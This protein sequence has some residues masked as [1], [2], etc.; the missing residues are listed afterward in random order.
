MERLLTWAR[1]ERDPEVGAAMVWGLRNRDAIQEFLLHPIAPMAREAALGLPVNDNTVYFLVQALLVGR[2]P[3][4]D[5]ILLEKLRGARSGLVAP[6]VEILLEAVGKAGSEE[7]VSL[8]ACLPQVPLFRIF[9]EGEAVPQWDPK[10][11][12]QDSE[13]A[14][15]WH[16]LARLVETALLAQPSAELVRHVVSRTAGDESF[17]RRHA[18]F[19]EAA[20]GHCQA[21]FSPELLGDLE[22][23]TATASVD[24]LSRLAELLVELCD[25]LDG[26]S[27]RQAESLLE[28]WKTRSPDL[29][30]RIY[31]LQLETHRR[32]R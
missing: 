21:V 25:R 23:L 17:G 2:A 5:R 6:V 4:I 27:A 8:L 7:I 24:K 9:V 32:S 10:Q 22:R 19:L 29:K 13:R 14:R 26:P 28:E 11:T 30:L 18:P 12:A 16:Q 1:Q 3:D 31:H 15:T 20:A